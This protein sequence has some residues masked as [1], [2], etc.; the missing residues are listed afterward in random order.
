MSRSLIDRAW[1][2]LCSHFAVLAIMFIVCCLVT[3]GV[4]LGAQ[5]AGRQA[6]FAATRSANAAVLRSEASVC[7]RNQIQRTYDRVDEF[8]QR[9]MTD[10]I[11]SL[12]HHRPP[13]LKQP[14]VIAKLYLGILNCPATYSPSNVRDGGDPIYLQRGDQECFIH[15]VVTHYFLREAPTTNP[16]LLRAICASA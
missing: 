13:H 6:G 9:R 5:A 12:R 3:T 11:N 8:Y 14:P 2:W 1:C 10:A 7:N 16:R 15:L 4:W